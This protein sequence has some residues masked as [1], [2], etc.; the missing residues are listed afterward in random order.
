MG[1]NELVG[2]W[3]SVSGESVL[4]YTFNSDNTFQL[5][6]TGQETLTGTWS[7]NGNQ[8]SLKYNP[9]GTE[10][11]YDYTI[12]GNKLTMSYE[13]FPSLTLTKK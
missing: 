8:L 5:A 11:L 10:V 2:T 6:T 9:S 1:G 4:S 12:N 7:I 13:D 3:E